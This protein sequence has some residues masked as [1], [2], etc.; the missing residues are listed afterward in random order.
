MKSIPD[1]KEKLLNKIK[2]LALNSSGLKFMEVCGTHTV[3]IYRNGIPSILPSNIDLISG[4]GCPVCVTGADFID[5]AV[6]YLKR[7][8]T[9]LTFGDML[10]VPGSVSSVSYTHLTLPTN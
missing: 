9:I 5:K 3:S 6:E 4:P 7:G 2:E 1:M 10:R 8:Y